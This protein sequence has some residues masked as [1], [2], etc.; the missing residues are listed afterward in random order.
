MHDGIAYAN[1]VAVGG[2]HN[3]RDVKNVKNV[4]REKLKIV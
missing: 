1:R 2:V 3:A 4:R